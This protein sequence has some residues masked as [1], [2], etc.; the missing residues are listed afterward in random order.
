MNV[1]WAFRGIVIAA[2]LTACT[3]NDVTIPA[4]PMPEGCRQLIVQR[5]QA[6]TQ[7]GMKDQLS[8]REYSEAV[9]KYDY[10]DRRIQ[11]VGCYG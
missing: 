4:G 1:R 8:E 10:Y 3:T 11:E 9:E 5:R 2:V 6:A 7:L